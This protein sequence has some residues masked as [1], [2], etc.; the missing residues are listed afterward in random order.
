VSNN[1]NLGENGHAFIRKMLTNSVILEP[2]GLYKIYEGDFPPPEQAA[3]L[4][5][6]ILKDG[7]EPREKGGTVIW[8]HAGRLRVLAVFEDSDVHNSATEHNDRTWATGDV[9]ELFFKPTAAR[10]DYF[11]LHLTPESLTLQ[12]HVPS[13]EGLTKT[14]FEKMFHQSQF[15]VKTEKFKTPEYKGWM[16]YMDIPF[17]GILLDCGIDAATF[18]VCRYNYNDS[19]DAPD[20]CSTTRFPKGGF[21]QP[22]YYHK[23]VKG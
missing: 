18:T 20:I 22:D 7:T 21:H 19:W 6:R 5:F 23:M 3:I 10:T 12:L 11:E 17:E 15:V 16:G 1:I 14:Q 4:G 2:N 9:M 8:T 13:V